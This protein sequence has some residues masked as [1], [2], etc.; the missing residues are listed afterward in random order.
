MY[1]NFL[2]KWEC[3]LTSRLF[4]F[5]FSLSRPSLSR[6][7]WVAQRYRKMSK[8]SDFHMRDSSRRLSVSGIKVKTSKS[9]EIWKKDGKKGWWPREHDGG[10]GILILQNITKNR[11]KRRNGRRWRSRPLILQYCYKSKLFKGKSEISEFSKFSSKKKLRC[12]KSKQLL[13]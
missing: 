5:T 12:L 6:P 10:R 13:W 4:S 11:K 9:W 1:S 7:S 8:I 2:E 3:V